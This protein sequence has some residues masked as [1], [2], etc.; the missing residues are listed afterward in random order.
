MKKGELIKPSW[1][2][3]IVT[4]LLEKLAWLISTAAKIATELRDS[5]I[6]GFDEMEEWDNDEEDKHQASNIDSEMK[7]LVPLKAFKAKDK[8]KRI[9]SRL[10]VSLERIYALRRRLKRE[11]LNKNK[12]HSQLPN[13][14]KTRKQTAMVLIQKFI[15]EHAH[16]F[17]TTFDVRHYL[18]QSNKIDDTPSLCTIRNWMKND[19][20]LSFKKVNI[21]FKPTWTSED[22]ITK[23]KYLWIF[24]FLSENIY[25]ITYMDE[26]CICDSSIKQ[27]N[28]S[29]RGV[30]NFWFG[31]RKANK[32]NC[33]I[34]VST[35]GQKSIHIQKDP[36]N[37][38]AFAS[39]IVDTHDK[40][41]NENKNPD[42]R[43]VLVFDNASIHTT[44]LVKEAIAKTN[45]WALTLP[46]YTPEWNDS[47]LAI[48]IIKR[49]LDKHL[50]CNRWV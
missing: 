6:W 9:A 17:F 23:L 20:M 12:L 29:S 35:S 45:W 46:P 28:W 25:H 3:E 40:L 24:R 41:I 4:D 48:N 44:K 16:K 15:Q 2:T 8:P 37:S 33:I 42:I 21:R 7:I 22:L 27:Y 49:R 30:Q 32:F 10:G 13:K 26:F 43:I 14:W 1:N 50:K 5:F 34:A 38:A 19:F 11:T 39:F 36:I 47:E 31:R 18:E